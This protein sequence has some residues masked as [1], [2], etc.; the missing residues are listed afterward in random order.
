MIDS[1]G[2]CVFQNSIYISAPLQLDF[3]F[4]F[5]SEGMMYCSQIKTVVDT[6]AEGCSSRRYQNL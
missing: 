1:Q 5:R 6:I 4:D 3:A 2:P